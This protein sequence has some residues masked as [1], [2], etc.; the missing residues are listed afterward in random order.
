MT[1]AVGL[2]TNLQPNPHTLGGSKD[3]QGLLGSIPE[4]D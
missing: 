4:D 1:R 2:G 3:R